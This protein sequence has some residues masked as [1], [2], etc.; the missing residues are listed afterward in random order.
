MTSMDKWIDG[1]PKVYVAGMRHEPGNLRSRRWLHAANGLLAV[2]RMA[3]VSM[4]VI[5][6][7]AQPGVAQSTA[8]GQ[9]SRPYDERLLRLAEL[10]GSVHFLRELC[11]GSDGQLWRERM[12]ELMEAEGSSALRKAK[13]SRSFNTGYRSYSRTYTTCT[14]SAQTAVGRFMIE[15]ADIAETMVKTVP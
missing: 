15:A 8:T 9:E 6:L 4:L 3:F 5:G 11:G 12:R 14:P 13:L 1:A 2:I 10:L 7:L